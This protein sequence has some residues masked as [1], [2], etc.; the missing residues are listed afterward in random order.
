[1]FSKACRGKGAAGI[2]GGAGIDE[3]F[4]WF[5]CVCVHER[6][7]LFHKYR[8]LLAQDSQQL[9][10]QEQNILRVCHLARRVVQKVVP[11]K[12]GTESSS[13]KIVLCIFPTLWLK[14]WFC[15]LF[16]C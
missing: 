16:D 12:P 13:G 1:M 8:S 2:R 14:S 15:Y 9:L 5:K 7:L 10:T 11:S 4:R 3:R 6:S